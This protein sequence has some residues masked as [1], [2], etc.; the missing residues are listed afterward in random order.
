MAIFNFMKTEDEKGQLSA[1]NN[2]F[3]VISFKIDGTIIQAN[4][5]FLNTLGYL[6][7][8]VVGK[9]HR[10][11]CESK[12]VNS[13]EYN[14]FWNDLSN[15]RAQIDE[16]KRIKKDGNSIWLQASYTPVMDNSG[17]VT[18]V[19]K[20]SQDITER[21]LIIVDYEGQLNAISK[22]NAVIEFD[23]NGIILKANNNFLN[24]VNYTQNDI[25]GKHHSMFCTTKYKNSSEYSQFWRELNQGEFSSGEYLR[26]G[27][28]NKEIWL[29][30]TYNPILDVDGKPYKVVKYAMDITANKQMVLSVEQNVKKLSK[31]SNN[32]YDTASSMSKGAEETMSGAE[33]V[34]T[35]MNQIGSSIINISDKVKLMV[36]TKLILDSSSNGAKIAKEAQVKSKETTTFMA[37]LDN[38]S[39]KIGETVKAIAQIAFQTNIL[40]LN[41]A[42]EAATA[43][44]AGKGFA[45]VAQE[46]RNL[47]SRSDEAA[48]DIKDAIDLIQTLIKTSTTSI[49]TI[50]ETIQEI[51]NISTDIVNAVV[52]QE[53]ISKEVLNI[54]DQTKL[55]MNAIAK[56]MENVAENAE[57]SGREANETLEASSELSDISDNLSIA[58]KSVNK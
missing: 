1:I 17:K 6:S 20:F 8:E 36:S 5:I 44:E 24:T 43:G 7:D 45:V 25:I 16:F 27:N 21:K 11:F 57:N 30:A 52:Q 38:K 26:I 34:S 51:T 37:E 19:I 32:L 3:A 53:I 22:S 18:R 54:I 4:E 13:S 41:A 28:N 9:H 10:I 31:S 48:K 39:E 23:M 14:S 40:S 46:V 42:V 12:F 29:Q 55:G 49:T 2:N 56:A 58:L 15:G 35:S 50:D 33:E 47:A